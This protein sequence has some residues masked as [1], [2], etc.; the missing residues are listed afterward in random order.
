MITHLKYT[1]Y[2]LILVIYLNPTLSGQQ[3]NPFDIARIDVEQPTKASTE[4]DNTSKQELTKLDTDNPFEISHIPIRKNQFDEIKKLNSSD[5]NKQENIELSY[6]PLWLIVLSM[7]LLAVIFIMRRDHLMYIFRSINNSNFMRSFGYTENYGLNKIY[8]LGYLIF[9]IN[10]SLFI[11]LVVSGLYKLDRINVLAYIMGFS[12]IFFVGKHIFN[13][14]LGWTFIK[15]KEA[16][17]YNFCISTFNNLN[18]IIFLIL[19]ILIVFG[20][21]TWLKPLALFGVAF[22]IIALLSRHYKGLLIIYKYFNSHFFHFFLYFCAFE[23]S[24]WLIVY[25]YVKKLF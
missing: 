24:P 10:C 22:F 7:C 19:N 21:D 5:E 8:T 25:A 12:I 2:L 9:L 11:Y 23:I 16:Q 14:L 6:I 1:S 4:L 15:T 20:N 17:L 18:G 13:S 3:G